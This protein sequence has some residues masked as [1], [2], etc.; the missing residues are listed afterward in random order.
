MYKGKHSKRRTTSTSRNAHNSD[1]KPK[2]FTHPKQHEWTR[3]PIPVPFSV[4]DI[5][6]PN[7]QICHFKKLSTKLQKS[8]L[9]YNLQKFY[10]THKI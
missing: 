3:K 10:S 5:F 1:I 6:K 7:A 4:R 9:F 2:Q 8:N